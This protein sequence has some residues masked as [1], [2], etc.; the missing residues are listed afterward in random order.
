MEMVL[1]R[2]L[3]DTSA[4]KEDK[5]KLQMM[6]LNNLVA[7]DYENMKR[8]FL[9]VI[10]DLHKQESQELQNKLGVVPKEIRQWQID[11]DP[12][13]VNFEVYIQ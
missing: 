8:S 10:N 2:Q 3:T 7:S 1:K 13:P 9:E 5:R 11:N 12:E 4:S 6:Y